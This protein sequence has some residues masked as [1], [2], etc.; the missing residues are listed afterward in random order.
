MAATPPVLPLP[1]HPRRAQQLFQ[2]ILLTDAGLTPHLSE[3]S[4]PQRLHELQRLNLSGI[5]EAKRGTRFQR[6]RAA[7]DSRPH[8][9]TEAVTLQLAKD[10]STLEIAPVNVDNRVASVRL[11]DIKELVL[12]ATPAHSVSLQLDADNN[13]DVLGTVEATDVFVAPSVESFNRWMVALTCGVNAF[14]QQSSEPAFPDSKAADLVWQGV[15][16]RVFELA[17]VLPLATVIKNVTN[18]LPEQDRQLS[19]TLRLRLQFLRCVD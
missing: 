14:Q 11:L 6:I 16:L 17:Q 9:E 15:R 4:L 8:V 3:K 1:L 12:H 7:T 13:V 19:E 5:Q 2:E 18:S 10:G